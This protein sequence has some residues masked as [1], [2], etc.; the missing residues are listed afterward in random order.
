M[1]I[2]VQSLPDR[3]SKKHRWIFALIIL[4]PFIVVGAILI[5]VLVSTPSS[6]DVEVTATSA[7]IAM[8]E[9]EVAVVTYLDTSRPGFFEPAFQMRAAAIRL[10]DGEQLWDTHLNDD[11]AGDA[12][13]LAGDADW[14]YV[15]TDH[16]L[17]ILDSSS[18][19]VHAEGADVDGLGSGAVFEAS[20]YGYDEGADVVTVL[21]GTGEILQIPVGRTQAEQADLMT[22]RAWRD[23]L[24][25]SSHF[26]DSALTQ[27][28]DVA[29]GSDGTV[30]AIESISEAVQRS[31]LEITPPGGPPSR[32]TEFVDAAILPGDLSEVPVPAGIEQGFLLVQHRE[33]INAEQIL[34]S[35][36]DAVTGEIVSSSEMPY[37]AV[38][39]I[40]GGGSTAVIS[41]PPGA[42]YANQLLILGEDGAFTAVPIGEMPWWMTIL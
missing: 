20:A 19:E 37:E 15:G 1:D 11:L 34:L 17:V 2:T 42:W 3:S 27:T 40:T 8:G 25:T 38:R 30:Y 10:S 31:I 26:D 29:E 24:S 35:A 32:S 14:V 7:V 5:A 9:E 21:S 28:V 16:G 22:V 13:V 36:V 4:S 23:V 12:V 6:R 41:T 39:A 18:G 33:S